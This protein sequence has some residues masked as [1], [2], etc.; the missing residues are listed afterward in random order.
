MHFLSGP[1]IFGTQWVSLIFG[2][3]HWKYAPNQQTFILMKLCSRT[4]TIK[5]YLKSFLSFIPLLV[6]LPILNPI[7]ENFFSHTGIPET[8]TFYKI[9]ILQNH[10]LFSGFKNREQFLILPHR[11]KYYLEQTHKKIQTQI[12]HP[13]FYR[14]ILLQLM[15]HHH[16]RQF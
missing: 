9:T 6:S 1:R 7:T 11:L 8:S 15:V 3:F 14:Q 16:I 4:S 5:N 13:S 2:T 10:P 12:V